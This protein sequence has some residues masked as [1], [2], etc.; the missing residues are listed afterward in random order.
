MNALAKTESRPL[1]RVP[2]AAEVVEKK[3]YLTFVLGGDRQRRVIGLANAGA[4]VKGQQEADR[5]RLPGRGRRRGRRQ[6]P[7]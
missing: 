4:V 5:R 3:Q 6:G 1:A 2:L 7:A